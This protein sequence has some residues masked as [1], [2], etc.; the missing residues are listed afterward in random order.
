MVL[1]L[2]IVFCA[3]MMLEDIFYQ[4]TGIELNKEF[5]SLI[6]RKTRPIVKAI[7]EFFRP[8]VEIFFHLIAMIVF[9]VEIVKNFIEIIDED[10]KLMVEDE[11]TGEGKITPAPTH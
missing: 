11:K 3:W 4:Q 7:V 6:G 2:M 1:I 8:I 9:I 5:F 10:E